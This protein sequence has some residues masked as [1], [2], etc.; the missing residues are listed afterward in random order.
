MKT[1][2]NDEQ[3]QTMDQIRAFLAGSEAGGHGGALWLDCRDLGQVWVLDL[4]QTQK[5]TAAVLSRKDNGVF[6]CPDRAADCRLSEAGAIRATTAA[7][8]TVRQTLYGGG[9]SALGP[10]R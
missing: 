10:H 1:H 5:R 7:S 8:L 3:I 2:M 4:L 9:Y 6:P